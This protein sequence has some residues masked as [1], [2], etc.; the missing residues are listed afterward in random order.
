MR[1]LSAM[2]FKGLGLL[3][4]EYEQ[5]I[6]AFLSAFNGAEC[7]L[8]NAIQYDSAYGFR[9][10]SSYEKLPSVILKMLSFL[11]KIVGFIEFELVRKG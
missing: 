6:Q 3:L 9:A 10:M 5:H 4:M 1:I 8:E 2:V 7:T 11:V